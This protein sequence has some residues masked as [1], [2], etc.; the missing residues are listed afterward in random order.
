MASLFL[1]NLRRTL[2]WSERYT[3]TDMLYLARGSFWL[4]LGQMVSM[5]VGFALSVTFANLIPKDV[6]GN[7]KFVFSIAG[8]LSAFT[9]TT[10]GT[11]ITQAVARGFEGAFARGFRTYLAWSIPSVLA[12]FALAGYYLLQ[13]NT[14]VGYSLII[15]AIFS[16]LLYGFNL[17]DA[18]LQGKRDFRRS[19]MYGLFLG[20]LPPVSLMALA[21]LGFRTS[22]PLFF[23]V[24]YPII[25]GLSAIFHF[26]TRTLYRPRNTADPGTDRYAWHLFFM[27]I[28]GRIASYLDKILVFHFLGAVPLAVYSFALAPSQYALRFNGII[29]TLALPK[30]AARDIPTIKKTLPRK[31]LLHCLVAAAVTALYLLLIPYAFR[32]V[33]PKYMDAIPYARALGLT[34]LLAPGVWLSQTLVAHMRKRELYILNI[35]NPAVELG[36]YAILLPYFGLWGI[37]WAVVLS[38]LAGTLTSIWMFIRLREDDRGATGNAS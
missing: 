11:A 21:F 26:R 3:K 33:F 35:V 6:Y 8:F 18:Y 2:R 25:V 32:L 5:I 12:A 30:L 22:V 9:L 4:S 37:V 16:P 13:G 24:Y 29:G 31:I 14:G 7:Y 38:G 36:L 10:M 27:N 23:L 19:A 17:Y 34:I 20:V 15:V 28:P 1:E